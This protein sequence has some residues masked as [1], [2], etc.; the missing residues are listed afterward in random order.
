MLSGK[1][2]IKLN[3]DVTLMS[4]LASIFIYSIHCIDWLSN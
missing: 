2:Y 1:H 4:V 3:I